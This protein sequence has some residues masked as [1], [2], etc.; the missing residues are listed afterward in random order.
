MELHEVIEW[1]YIECAKFYKVDVIDIIRHNKATYKRDKKSQEYRNNVAQCKRMAIIMLNDI[2]SKELVQDLYSMSYSQIRNI[3]HRYETLSWEK[4]N[5]FYNDTKRM[6]L[7]Q[8]QSK[9]A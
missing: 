4:E 9:A 2:Y 8:S 1:V 5:I 3:I 6:I 7:R